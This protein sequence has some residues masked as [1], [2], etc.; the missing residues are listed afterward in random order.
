MYQAAQLLTKTNTE[1]WMELWDSYRRVEGRIEGPIVDRN[2]KGRPTE[3]TN[4]DPY[5]LSGAKL[6]TK[7]HL[8]PGPNPHSL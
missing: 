2:S 1:T 4:L 3:S 5:G 7:E 6:Q 8:P